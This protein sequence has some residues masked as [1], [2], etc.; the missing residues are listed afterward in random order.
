MGV[1]EEG[2]GERSVYR[3]GEWTWRHE[4]LPAGLSS[5]LEACLHELA[6]SFKVGRGRKL[7]P[8]GVYIHL[9]LLILST[10]W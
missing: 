4:A 8:R 7:P 9:E 3:E 2:Q 10:W 5:L 6:L 1:R